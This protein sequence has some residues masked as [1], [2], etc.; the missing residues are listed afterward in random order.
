MTSWNFP[1][2]AKKK[3]NLVASSGLHSE[4]DSSKCWSKHYFTQTSKHGEED[5]V[6]S[7]L[8]MMMV[9]MMMVMTMTMMMMVTMLPQGWIWAP[10]GEPGLRGQ[11][12]C[13][14]APSAIERPI[15]DEEYMLVGIT[16]MITITIGK[17]IR[18][19][20]LCDLKVGMVQLVHLLM[21]TNSSDSWK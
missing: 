3:Y 14:P 20:G 7:G 9:M 19:M 12:Q 16:I 18:I 2:I 17:K 6:T 13:A 10:L 4:V 5:S 21:A 11:G 1:R 15:W 8:D